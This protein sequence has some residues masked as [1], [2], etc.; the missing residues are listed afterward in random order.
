MNTQFFNNNQQ[1]C[2]SEIHNQTNTRIYNRNIPSQ[3][4][5]PYLD[6]RPVSTKYSI[7]PIVDPRAE[8]KTKFVQTPTYRIDHVFNPGN[9]LYAP[10]SGFSSGVNIES[11]LRNQI[12]ALQKC[13]QSVFVPNSKS[14]L[15][16]IN[17]KS[18][19][20]VQQ[21]FQELFREEH[22]SEFNPNPNPEIIGNQ[23]FLNNTRSQ[24]YNIDQQN[25]C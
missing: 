24:M 25:T 3:M 23:L 2:S 15:Y 10:W 1:E 17:M 9:A 8:I 18:K 16:N 12:Y 11:E 13:D 20:T 7:L 4:L 6:V 5:Q 14:D 19:Y 22:F 21:P